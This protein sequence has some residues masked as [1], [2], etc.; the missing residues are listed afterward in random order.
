MLGGVLDVTQLSLRTAQYLTL[1]PL[2]LLAPISR[3]FSSL[4]LN[5]SNVIFDG[6]VELVCIHRGLS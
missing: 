2:Q 4:F 3:E 5:F 1:Q 6:T